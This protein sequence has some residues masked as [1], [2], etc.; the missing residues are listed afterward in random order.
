MKELDV[1]VGPF[2]KGMNNRVESHALPEG[3]ARN[4]VNLDVDNSGFCRTRKGMSKALSC[5]NS[6]F[7]YNCPLGM[8]FVEGPFLKQFNA[9][10]NTSTILFG[11]ITGSY[12]TFDYFNGV[13]YFSD[14]VVNR[15]IVSGNVYRW[16]IGPPSSP[17]IEAVAGTYSAGVYQAALCFVDSQGVESGSSSVVSISVGDSTGFTFGLPA[18]LDPQ[19]VATRI[20][21]STP[22]GSELYHV[23]DTTDT[24]YTILAGRY[25]EGNTLETH[26]ISSPPPGRILRHYNGREYIAD[27]LGTVWYSEPYS[28]DQF[29]LGD[30][31]LQ[32]EDPVDIMEPVTGGIYF[33][34]GDRTEFWI[35][36]PEEGF[37][38]K[39]KF[40]YGAILGTGRKLPNSENVAWQST[41]GMVIGTPSGECKNMQEENVAVENAASGS[42]LVREKDGI[43]QFIASLHQPVDS[44]MAATSWFDAEVIRRGE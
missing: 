21:L 22:N 23:G 19:V 29:R 30:N 32:F 13:L 11:D 28:F 26:V 8:F 27:S 38:V 4:L 25:D 36:N 2:F 14:G 44:P 24:T 39:D 3:T 18:I 33:A 37:E 41:R 1:K 17:I 7:G 35:G 10:T 31:F 12:C 15:K 40:S 43:R 42:V 16:G 5:I 9:T 6:K 20:Y 34:Y